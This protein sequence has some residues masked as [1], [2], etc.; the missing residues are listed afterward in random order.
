MS[1]VIVVVLGVSI[2]RAVSVLREGVDP[3]SMKGGPDRNDHIGMQS[4]NQR[5]NGAR[6]IE[7]NKSGCT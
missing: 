7:I 4:N 6:S 5:Y 3:I 2:R 1:Q